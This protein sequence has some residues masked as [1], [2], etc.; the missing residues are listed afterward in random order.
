M[1]ITISLYLPSNLPFFSPIISLSPSLYFH[2]VTSLS[3][4]CN[5]NSFPSLPVGLSIFPSF[6][7]TVSLSPSSVRTTPLPSIT[8]LPPPHL[9]HP[10][11]CSAS[12]AHCSRRGATAAPASSA[13]GGACAT[14]ARRT[15]LPTTSTARWRKGAMVGTAGAA[16]CLCHADWSGATA[17]LARAA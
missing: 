4:L 7:A 14:P 10:S 6:S 3:F 8:P 12:A 16:R 15:T 11:P 5:Y 1:L 9:P 2:S 17:Q 13:S